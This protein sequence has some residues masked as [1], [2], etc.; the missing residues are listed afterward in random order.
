MKLVLHEII[1]LAVKPFVWLSAIALSIFLTYAVGH[2]RINDDGVTIAFYETGS[3]NPDVEDEMRSVQSTVQE[4]AGVEVAEI[5]S[6]T[7]DIATQ[8]VEDGADIAVTRTKDGWRLTLRSRSSLEHQRLVRAA[9]LLGATIVQKTPWFI[10]LYS[11]LQASADSGAANKIQISGVTA[12]PGIHSRIFV[13]KVIVLIAYFMAF[14]MVSRSMVRDFAS[15]ITPVLVVASGGDWFA[16]LLSKLVVGVFFGTMIFSVLL[17]FSSQVYGFG[18]KAGLVTIFVVQLLWLSASSLVGISLA[19]IARTEAR[20]YF[21]A[22]CYLIL[23]IVLSGL[24]AKIDDD[25]ALLKAIS[26]IF[27]INYG[28]D[29]V[30]NWLFFGSLPSVSSTSISALIALLLVST[31]GTY[32]SFVIYRRVS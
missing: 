10:I 2:L 24:I 13:A 6:L 27:P 19:M 21:L 30:S 16:Y 5:K 18:M 20:I 15:N 8:M 9:Q 7:K 14:A 28:I 29:I 26:L 22:F 4:L 25:D 11:Q 12:D 23:L 1:E 31:A 17:L 3:S 32:A